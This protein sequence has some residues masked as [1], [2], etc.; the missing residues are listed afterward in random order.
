MG[1]SIQIELVSS[2]SS[3]EETSKNEEEMKKQLRSVVNRQIPDY[4]REFGMLTSSL[5]KILLYV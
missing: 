5:M 4:Q 3:E 1:K 2:S